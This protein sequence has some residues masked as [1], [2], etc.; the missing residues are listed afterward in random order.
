MFSVVSIMATA[1]KVLLHRIYEISLPNYIALMN[2]PSKILSPV[3]SP[4]DK[5]VSAFFLCGGPKSR[6]SAK[7]INSRS[8]FTL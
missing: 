7:Y 8:R 2:T 5:L 3:R 4:I 1:E 6:W